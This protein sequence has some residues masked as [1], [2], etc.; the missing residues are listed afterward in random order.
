M[1]ALTHAYILKYF[2][3]MYVNFYC[4]QVIHSESIMLKCNSYFYVILINVENLEKS[5]LFELFVLAIKPF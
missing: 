3:V 4:L 1:S 2:R 5:S